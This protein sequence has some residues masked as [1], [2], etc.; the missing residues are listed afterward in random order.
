[1]TTM[2][3]SF[4]QQC[5]WRRATRSFS[6]LAPSRTWY[7]SMN[8]KVYHQ[9]CHVR[10][11]SYTLEIL[12]FFCF[13]LSSYVQAFWTII[14]VFYYR[15]L[16]WPMKT[17]LSCMRHVEEDR[18]LLLEYWDM[19]WRCVHTHLKLYTLL[20][21]KV[22]SLLMSLFWKNTWRVFGKLLTSAN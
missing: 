1:M 3:Q 19:D 12:L 8:K 9:S 11:E 20:A 7:W 15:L 4:P 21:E 5:H 14:H 6:N 18:G 2:S 10:S 22:M 13:F 16:I 17:H